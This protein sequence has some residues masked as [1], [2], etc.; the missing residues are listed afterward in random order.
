MY[1][2]FLKQKCLSST[3]FPLGHLK[4]REK[5]LGKNIFCIIQGVYINCQ[6]LKSLLRGK[7]QVD[8]SLSKVPLVFDS[9][10]K[11]P[12]DEQGLNI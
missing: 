5:S 3:K 2:M 4:I 8:I 9:L 10:Y 12:V 6:K 7:Y 11:H 1:K